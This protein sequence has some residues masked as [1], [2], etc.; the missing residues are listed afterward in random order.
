MFPLFSAIDGTLLNA[1]TVLIGGVFGT[2][3]GNRLPERIH[4]AL[5]GAIG[6]FTV[7]IGILSAITTKNPLIL[8]GALLVGVLIGEAIDLEKGLQRLGDWLQKRLARPGSTLSEAFVTSSLVFC[9]GPLSILGALDNGLSGNIT[10]LA[11]KATLDGFTAIAFSATLGWGVLL[12][13][14]T[15]LL[16]QGALSLSAGALAPVLGANSQTIVELTATGGL[17]LV[18]VGL[19]LLKIRD[20]RVANYLPALIV[21][22]LLVAAVALWQQY[23][24]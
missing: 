6:L 21:A 22:P 15:I 5:L 23:V 7:L 8:L 10:K 12:S 14:I 13:I 19:K 1:L 4:Q 20:L 11:I 3:I 16:Y 9:V 24:R 18:A 17:I 2:I